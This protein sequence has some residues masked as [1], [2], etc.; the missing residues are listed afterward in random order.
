M[1]NKNKIKN[2][3]PIEYNNNTTSNTISYNK[4]HFKIPEFPVNNKQHINIW[5]ETCTNLFKYN[6]IY[7]E[8]TITTHIMNQLPHEILNKINNKLIFN[9]FYPI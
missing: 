7:N 8:K 6:G 9:K 4:L 1:A 3:T 5:F 2:N